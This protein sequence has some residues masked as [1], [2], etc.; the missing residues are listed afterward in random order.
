MTN[1]YS[2]DIIQS[3][4]A[5]TGYRTA[6]NSETSEKGKIMKYF[7]EC[8]KSPNSNL[9]EFYA[10]QGNNSYYLFNQRFRRSVYDYFKN[11]QPISVALDHSKANHNTALINVINRL[12]PSIRYAEKY[13]SVSILNKSGAVYGKKK[14]RGNKF[15]A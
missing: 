14:Y 9:L 8:K 11:S 12:L 5:K 2:R 10:V 15:A 3:H 13:Y 7:I 1:D 4:Q 6:G